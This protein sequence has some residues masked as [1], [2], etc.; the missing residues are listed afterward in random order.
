M[1]KFQISKNKVMFIL[2]AVFLVTLIIGASFAYF[3]VSTVNNGTSTTILGDSIKVGQ[4]TLVTNMPELK[5]NITAK[6]LS[7]KNVGKTYYATTSGDAVENPTLGNGEYIFST[8]SIT[9]SA[10]KVNCKY[11]Y[12]IYFNSDYSI[13]DYSSTNNIKVQ[14]TNSKGEEYEYTLEDLK[15]GG[16][17][18]RDSFWNLTHGQDQYLK[19]KFSFTNIYD[20][21]NEL[22]NNTF[23]INISPMDFSCDLPFDPIKSCEDYWSFA[24]C[25]A[26]DYRKI[27]GLWDSGL[28][29]DGFR[30][31]G[32]G[33]KVCSYRNG[34]Y[35]I[36]PSS[37]SCPTLYDMV[38]IDNETGQRWESTFQRQ[39]YESDSMY[40]YECTEIESEIVEATVTEPDNYVCFGADSIEE[41]TSDEVDENGLSGIDKHMYRII[42]I[43]RDDNGNSYFKLIKYRH[44][45]TGPFNSTSMMDK[46]WENSD[47]YNGLNGDYFLTNTNY[48]YLQKDKWLNKIEDWRWTAFKASS[49]EY[50]VGNSP[51][52]S[53]LNEM[54]RNSKTITLGEWT[55]PVAKI[56]LMYASDFKLSN[57]NKKNLG[58]EYIKATLGWLHQNNI[59]KNITSSDW[60]M[61]IIDNGNY[62][63][64]IRDDGSVSM[65]YTSSYGGY[66]PVFYLKT[67]VKFAEGKGTYE[68][69][70]F[71]E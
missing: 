29:G 16:V 52:D 9:E 20:S 69:P 70:Y 18:L 17:Y 10:R 6:M 53:Y 43:F 23:R 56:G 39:C 15:N 60:T 7:E 36:A 5:L 37:S 65:G 24:S 59:D 51:V 54:N 62:I 71:I 3:Q 1:K 28:E 19:V 46:N 4:S 33:S 44:L 63:A 55:Y 30:Y 57:K 22:A 68:E 45:N 50:D 34:E 67:D 42:G 48:S 14:I 47:L 25:M 49:G 26:G 41:C 21:Q 11:D 35:K 27:D 64:E 8:A 32:T 61:S 40:T 2:G 31:V 66:R 12:Q 38:T 13:S 58:N